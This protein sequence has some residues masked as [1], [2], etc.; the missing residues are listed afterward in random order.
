M[1]SS[2]HSSQAA[3]Y[4][5]AV[6]AVVRALDVLELLSRTGNE[7]TLSQLGRE[8]HI[9]LSSLSAILRTLTQRGYVA[10]DARTRRYR[11]NTKVE[12]LAGAGATLRAAEAVVALGQSAA[13]GAGQTRELRYAL[14]LAAHHLAS[15]LLDVAEDHPSQDLLPEPVWRDEASGP[16]H[17]AE[18]RHFLAD[19]LLATLSCLNESGYPYSVP[20]WYLWE[21]ERFWVVPRGRAEWAR[22]LEW[23]PHISL[24]ISEPNPPLRR[25]LVEGEA[26]P[27]TG[28]GSG[29]RALE[30]SA[31]MAERYLGPAAASYLGA[32]AAQPR[33]VFMIVPSKLVT[34][35]GLAQHPRYRTAPG[36][37]LPPIR[38]LPERCR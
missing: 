4:A 31:R 6:P 24:T 2:E 16:L 12:D 15:V 8:L 37:R 3:S 10:Q 18:V 25:V 21:N 38:G 27:M 35:R 30:L 23:N 33:R 28:P 32:T 26:T 14:G 22:Y 9:S 17:P 20:V 11:L 1:D 19:D 5:E 34:W 7:L 36:Q 29:E 13:G